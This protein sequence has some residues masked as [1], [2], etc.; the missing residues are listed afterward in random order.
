M[1]AYLRFRSLE[2]PDT[3][4]PRLHWFRRRHTEVRVSIT[5]LECGDSRGFPLPDLAAVMARD[6]RTRAVTYQI[7]RLP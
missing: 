6:Y 5:L 3:Q 2:L 1:L 7:H 4:P